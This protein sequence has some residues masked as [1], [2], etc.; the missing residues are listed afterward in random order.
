MPI[1]NDRNIT[2]FLK[3]KNY[4]NK[5]FTF[6]SQNLESII[7]F[8]CKSI[9]YDE[10]FYYLS[11][12]GLEKN[13]RKLVGAMDKD[14]IISLITH[15]GKYLRET[16]KDDGAFVYGY[17][18]CFD[19]EIL[20]YNVIRHCLSVISLMEIYTLSRDWKYENAIKKT[21]NYFVNNYIIG[22]D[23]NTA[24]V[25][26]K[27]NDNE[28]R[29]GALGL[30]IVMILMYSS[31]FGD[32]DHIDKAVRI[33]NFIVTMQNGTTGEF[34]HVLDYPSLDFK[35]KFRIVYYSG[36]ACY[37]LLKLYA[38][39]DNDKYLRVC[40]KAFD[41]FIK[42]HYEQYYDHWLA[43]ASNELT[44]YVPQDIYY[45]F[46]LENA[47]IKIDFIN[48]RSTTWPTF[49]E[50]MNSTFLIIE[51][52]KQQN[53]YYLLQKYNIEKFYEVLKTRILR[54][55]NGIM[56]PELAM[57]YK[58]PDRMLYAIFGRHHFFRVRNDDVAHHLIGYCHF[59]KNISDNLPDF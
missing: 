27:H 56:Y 22:I 26:E 29:L 48:K 1:F 17:Y 18:P 42:N 35:D 3:N 21:Y 15:S 44:R 4:S 54:Q 28:V 9:F 6:S 30:S 7:I 51:R 36:E 12:D 53:K 58:N 16:V 46:A 24:V 38:L 55:M 40:V 57:F 8:D 2:F 10:K 31:I 19:E 23:Q 11:S 20:S 49:L 45:N 41:F 43:Y 5:F 50:L 33:G 14:H 59:I 34:F 39:T 13:I 37:G 47:F 25:V 32:I 52:I